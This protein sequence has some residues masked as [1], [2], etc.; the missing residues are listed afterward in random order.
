MQL[1]V[2]GLVPFQIV[3]SYSG[4][5]ALVTGAYAEYA[6]QAESFRA[7]ALTTLRAPALRQAPGFELKQWRTLAS[8]L[9]AL[10]RI[11]FSKIPYFECMGLYLKRLAAEIIKHRSQVVEVTMPWLAGVRRFLPASVKVVLLLQN[12]EAIWY[13]DSLKKSLW[14]AFFFRRLAQLERS[15]VQMADHVVVLTGQDREEII[16]RY[17]VASSRLSVVPP[18]YAIK[19]GPLLSRAGHGG[20]IRAVFMGSRFSGNQEAVR[21]LL[22][23]VAPAVKGMADILVAGTVCGYFRG[24]SVPSNVRLLG[25]VDHLD[26]FLKTGDVLLN[27]NFMKTGINI[28]VLD[29]L[30]CGLRVIS[31]PEG[32]RGYESLAGRIIRVGPVESFSSLMTGLD[33]FSDDERR[34]VEEYSWPRI[35]QK[36]LAIFQSLLEKDGTF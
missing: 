16:R 9:I 24:E 8:L 29:A 10:D 27:P 30:A 26:D 14:P 6:R 36:R 28:K 1:R 11:G 18:G 4:G 2:F 5:Q 20:A 15:A 22:D 23:V 3:P 13:A 7:V 32:A 17:G 31:T 21:I 25:P 12:V 34:L 33:P 35:V 19:D